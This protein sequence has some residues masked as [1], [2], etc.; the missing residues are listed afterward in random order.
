MYYRDLCWIL[1]WSYYHVLDRLFDLLMFYLLYLLLL[2]HMD[3]LYNKWLWTDLHTPPV[4]PGTYVTSS[5]ERNSSSFCF[6]LFLYLWIKFAAIWLHSQPPKSAVILTRLCAFN[7]WLIHWAFVVPSSFNMRQ[8]CPVN[9]PRYA[10]GNQF[11]PNAS[12]HRI[13]AVIDY[14]SCW[15]M[16]TFDPWT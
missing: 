11:W 4:I 1:F 12:S 8:N 9:N 3:Y 5:R 10:T 7:T 16:V 15:C 6:L 14:S 2:F 13:T